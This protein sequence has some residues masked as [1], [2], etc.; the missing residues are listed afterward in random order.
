MSPTGNHDSTVPI[1]SLETADASGSL[2]RRLPLPRKYD[3]IVEVFRA[4]ETVAAILSNRNEMITLTKMKPAVL[5]LVRTTQLQEKHLGQFLTVFPNCYNYKWEKVKMPGSREVSYQL[6]MTP[7]LAISSVHPT[8][9]KL[10][11]ALLAE[12]K[13]IFEA[14]VLEICHKHHKVTCFF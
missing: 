2:I 6:I 14:S 7:N 3:V 10:N 11:A 9:E 12:R 5:D 4:V 8:A 13:Q 1:S